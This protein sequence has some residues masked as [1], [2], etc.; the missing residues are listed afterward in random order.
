M[1]DGIKRK[2]GGGLNLRNNL[3]IVAIK[4]ATLPQ[5]VPFKMKGGEEL[6][7]HTQAPGSE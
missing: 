1:I 4:K 5:N 2:K 7:T 6:W 3:A